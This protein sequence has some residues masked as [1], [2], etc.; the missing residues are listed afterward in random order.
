MECE[1]FLEDYSDFLDGTLEEHSLTDYRYHLE[2]C[3]SCAEYDRVMRRGLHL[4]RALD[5]PE[6]QADFLPRLQR[7]FFDLPARAVG[8]GVRPRNFAVASLLAAAALFALVSLPLLRPEVRALEL[9]PVVIEAP[10][11]AGA[12]ASLWG[13]PPSFAPTASFLTVPD[14][15]SDPFFASTPRP[16]SL[17]R[18]P[19][20][21]PV[22][23]VE[24][25]ET[26]PE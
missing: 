26:A 12:V 8:V 21:A 23:P 5:P 2:R 17:F 18:T 9:P 24:N 15:S 13:P 14:L 10:E 6:A 1:E 4:V 19:L 11:D 3:P 7:R 16:Y 22:R 25:R 20:R